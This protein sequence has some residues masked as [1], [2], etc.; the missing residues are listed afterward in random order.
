M[1][2]E[3]DARANYCGDLYLL[4]NP[5]D[6]PRLSMLATSNLF[7]F[8]TYWNTLLRETTGIDNVEMSLIRLRRNDECKLR[9]EEEI[10]IWLKMRVFR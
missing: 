8:F 4:S 6:V 10:K 1:G 2:S 5:K 7:K 3:W 9:R